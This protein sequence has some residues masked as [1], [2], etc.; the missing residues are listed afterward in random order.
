[1]QFEQEINGFLLARL[2]YGINLRR[3]ATEAVG[4]FLY[5]LPDYAENLKTYRAQDNSAIKARLA[6]L[7]ADNGALARDFHK[8]RKRLIP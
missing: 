6:E 7:L 1:G 5:R 2:Q 3:A 4:N 8:K